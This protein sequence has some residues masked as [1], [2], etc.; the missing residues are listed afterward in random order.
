MNGEILETR[1]GYAV[2]K[3]LKESTFVRFIKWAY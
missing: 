1:N 3:E 2:L